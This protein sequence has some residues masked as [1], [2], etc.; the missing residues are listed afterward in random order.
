MSGFMGRREVITG[1]PVLFPA[2]EK[3]ARRRCLLA[4]ISAILEKLGIACSFGAAGFCCE[5]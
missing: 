4:C 3:C 5:V 1:L 2:D